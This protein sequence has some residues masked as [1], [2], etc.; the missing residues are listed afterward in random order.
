MLGTRMCYLRIREYSHPF[1]TDGRANSE[2]SSRGPAVGRPGLR[3]CPPRGCCRAPALHLLPEGTSET[4]T[5]WTDLSPLLS[6]PRCPWP[7]R[8]KRTQGRCGRERACWWPR[9]KRRPWQLGPSRPPGPSGAAWG[10]RTCGRKGAGWP[11]RFPRPQ[12]LE[13]QFWNWRPERTARPQ[14]GCG[15]PRARGAPRVSGARGASRK[16]RDCWED[17]FTRPAGA[18]GT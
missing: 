3:I 10:N 16:T 7:S 11:A 6:N 5:S 14:R 15:T 18:R 9:T 12:R 4:C 2:R 17:R 8:T 13:G 1:F